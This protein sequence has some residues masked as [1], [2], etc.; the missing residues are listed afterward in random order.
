M[1]ETML[2]VRGRKDNKDFKYRN[3]FFTEHGFTSTK[4]R[5]APISPSTKRTCQTHETFSHSFKDRP[6]LH[7]GGAQNRTQGESTP[8]NKKYEE[9]KNEP[10]QKARLEDVKCR[11]Q[12]AASTEAARPDQ[13]PQH[14][15][16]IVGATISPL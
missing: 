16:H 5:G 3:S 2:E 15:R 13:A 7:T 12:T 8:K 6:C 4:S 1:N 10:F 14:K 9:K 11:R